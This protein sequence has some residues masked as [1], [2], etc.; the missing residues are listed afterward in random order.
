M[1][2]SS[3]VSEYGAYN[4]RWGCREGDVRMYDAGSLF[5][6]RFDRA[7]ALDA[8]RRV[9]REGLGLRRA[10]AIIRDRGGWVKFNSEG[11]AFTSEFLVPAKE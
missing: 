4:R 1:R 8:L 5:K 6:L 9:E 11:G 10:E 7:P 2:C 3:S